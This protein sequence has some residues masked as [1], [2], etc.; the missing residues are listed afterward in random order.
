MQQMIGKMARRMYGPMLVM[1]FMIVILAF[2]I[3]YFNSQTAAAYFAQR[4]FVRET[5]LM[6]QR[7]SIEAIGLWL[8]Y[9]KFLGLGLILG[10]IVMALRVIIDN[11]QD[12]GKEVMS[13]LP[14]QKRLALPSAPWYAL[15]MPMVMM[16]GELIFIVALIVAVQLAGVAQQVFANPL[17]VIDAAGAGSVLLS[18]VQTI[19]ATA[20]W[21]VPL[22][23]L[24]IATEFLAVTM[25]LTTITYIL[26]SQTLML[27]QGIQIM[28]TAPKEGKIISIEEKRKAKPRKIAA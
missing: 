24:G 17:P 10:G 3:G 16:I 21:L 23:F 8:P 28:R 13:N 22:K 12:A 14:E 26:K 2:A 5:T 6:T 25:G 27:D 19:H 18:Q 20:A 11:L 15:A 9:L 4:K 7:A 1:G